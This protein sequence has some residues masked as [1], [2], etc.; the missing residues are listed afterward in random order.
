MGEGE[1]LRVA[2]ETWCFREKSSNPMIVNLFKWKT[3]KSSSGASVEGDL[4]LLRVNENNDLSL[5][6]NTRALVEQAQ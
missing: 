1:F 2:S 5:N 6:I 3:S 4:T